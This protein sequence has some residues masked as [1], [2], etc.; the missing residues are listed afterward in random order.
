M[1][2]DVKR[3]INEV[4]V[5]D[6]HIILGEPK[7]LDMYGEEVTVNQVNYYYEW[8]KFTYALGIF[9]ACY[10]EYYKSLNG[11]V[12]PLPDRMEDVKKF[13][14]NM[15]MV[16]QNKAWGK[17]AFQH[18]IKATAISVDVDKKWMKQKF[19]KDDWIEV[20]AWVYIYNILGV[21]KNLSNVLKIVRN[22]VS[23]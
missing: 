4:K 22:I 14:E 12:P 3:I 5:E 10:E 9:L 15:S 21:K 16:L 19:T 13:Q 7:K 20:F 18:L 23:H 1:Y 6:G 11:E 2:I 8:D 17:K